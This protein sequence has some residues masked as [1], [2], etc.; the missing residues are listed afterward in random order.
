MDDP[1]QDAAAATGADEPAVPVDPGPV[2]E[3]VPPSDARPPAGRTALVL[4]TTLAVVFA[5]TSV[6][7]G[8]LLAGAEGDDALEELR[9]T[10][11]SFGETLV[12]YD[13]RDPEAHR[14]AVLAFATGSF[15]EEYEDAFDQGLGAVIT[16]V[17]AVSKG[18]VKDVY[19]TSVDEERA[20]AIVVVDIEHD[21]TSGPSTLFDVYFR[22]TM[23]EV[24]GRWK[25]DQV[26]DLNFD[27]GGGAPPTGAVTTDTTAPPPASVP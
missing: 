13:Y 27:A 10:A 19:V 5:A 4:A 14:D 12:S 26:T 21:G 7:L 9:R 16:E 23:V 6:V 17:Q 11:G 3:A 8:I 1:Q 15:R 20:Q 24:G 2:A 22:L 25:V 18:F